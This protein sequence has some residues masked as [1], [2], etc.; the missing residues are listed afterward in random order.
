MKQFYEKVDLRSRKAMVDFLEN[1]FRYFTMNSWNRSTSFANNMKIYNLGLSKEIE[2]TL[3]DILF[4]DDN[5]D[6]DFYIKCL[7]A[8]FE[9]EHDDRYTACFNGRSGGYLVL[10]KMELVP[11]EYKS[12][13]TNCG[14]QNYASVEETGCK[15]GRCGEDTRVDY[16]NPLMQQR[17]YTG[18]YI[19]DEDFNDKEEW[20]MDSLREMVK[21]VQDFDTLCDDIVYECNYYA[22][23]HKVV[24]EEI[25][26]PKKVKRVVEKV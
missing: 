7:I 8:D 21:L 12:Y 6:L 26:V 4:S 18:R 3:Y 5:N 22:E 19:G 24:E 9:T 11:S 20:D 14:Q 10:Y 1:H 2:D 23:N 15:C 17:T 25:L 13:C 16:S